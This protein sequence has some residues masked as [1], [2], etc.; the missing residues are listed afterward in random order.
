MEYDVPTEAVHILSIIKEKIP[1]ARFLNKVDVIQW[2]LADTSFLQPEKHKYELLG[3]ERTWGVD[4]LRTLRPETTTTSNWGEVGE[5]IVRELLLA[6]GQVAVK[7]TILA[8]KYELDW[9]TP[10]HMIE[11]KSQGHHMT[12]TAD[13]KIFGVPFKYADVPDLYKKPVRVI[14]VGGAEVKARTRQLL[15]PVKESKQRHVAFWASEGFTFVGASQIL[16]ALK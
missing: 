15:D 12:G 8:E 11:A 16:R 2:L 9:E 7:P 6:E 10:T 14:L 3:L 13:E 1:N 5:E 4:L